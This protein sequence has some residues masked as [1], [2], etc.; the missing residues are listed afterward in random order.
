MI[1]DGQDVRIAVVRQE[2][3]VV[4]QRRHGEANLLEVEEVL[5]DGHLAEEDAVRD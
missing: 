4:A 1:G 5:H 2:Q 3:G